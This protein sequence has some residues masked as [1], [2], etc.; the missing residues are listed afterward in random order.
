ML[1]RSVAESERTGRESTGRFQT[2]L[3]GKT[4]QP[5]SDACR[6]WPSRTARA[7][8]GAATAPAASRMA[9][10][11]FTAGLLPWLRAAIPA[12]SVVRR[13]ARPRGGKLPAVRRLRRADVAE[14]EALR[15]R[16]R[17]ARR[18]PGAPH[19]AGDRAVPRDVG[20]PRRVP[21]ARRDARAG[22]GPRD[23]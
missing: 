20:R 8:A 1:R 6:S 18:R 21:R 17:A 13:A 2:L 16:D 4:G 19:P 23:A 14:R 7:A 12:L 22:R 10:S 5:P 15:L 11:L 9:G 3:D